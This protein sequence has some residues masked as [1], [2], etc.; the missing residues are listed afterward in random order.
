MYSPTMKTMEVTSQI[1]CHLHTSV[2]LHR[3]V[4][5]L[6]ITHSIIHQTLFSPVT[7]L[8]CRVFSHYS[9]LLFLE[10]A[11][12]HDVSGWQNPCFSIRIA[13]QS[14]FG[15]TEIGLV[16]IHGNNQMF[17]NPHFH[18]GRLMK[19]VLCIWFSEITN[20]F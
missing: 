10:C 8:N 15:K 1:W 2:T 19:Q 7:D 9:V 12:G 5:L 4:P 14:M 17:M 16:V 13:D 11:G 18:N 20:C 3:W 6:L